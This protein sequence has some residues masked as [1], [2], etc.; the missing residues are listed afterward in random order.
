M[1]DML[2]IFVDVYSKEGDDE[3]CSKEDRS[4]YYMFPVN[5]GHNF[6]TQLEAANSVRILTIKAQAS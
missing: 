6:D 4:R 1:W 2:L 3:G 5:Q